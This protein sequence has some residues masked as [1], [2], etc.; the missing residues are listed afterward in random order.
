VANA[1]K[2]LHKKAIE[3]ADGS[4][5][6]ED[7]YIPSITS[8]I[9][10]PLDL[11]FLLKDFIYAKINH[12]KIAQIDLAARIA[13][14]PLGIAYQAASFLITIAEFISIF[15]PFQYVL[16]QLGLIVLTCA[17]AVN[18]LALGLWTLEFIFESFGLYKNTTFYLKLDAQNPYN[19]TPAK[20]IEFL[21]KTF[22]ELSQKERQHLNSTRYIVEEEKLRIVKK[23][24]LEHRIRPWAVKK[25]QNG[26]INLDLTTKEGE[27]KARDLLK[28]VET[29]AHKKLLVNLLGITGALFGIISICLTLLATPGILPLS[30]FLLFCSLT[31]SRYLVTTGMLEHEGWHFSVSDCIPNFVKTV[32][33][34]IKCSAERGLNH[35]R[36]YLKGRQRLEIKAR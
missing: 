29:Q 21:K 6:K 33:N 17:K 25:L 2:K 22:F 5:I 10:A 16:S 1:K 32:A 30:V 3:N 36:D 18:V 27:R 35:C 4:W 12:D 19:N 23:M 31:T 14:F 7:P 34:K 11:V 15:H 8:L 24:H 9:T 20:S 26:L 13:L 28:M